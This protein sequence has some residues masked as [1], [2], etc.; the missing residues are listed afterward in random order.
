MKTLPLIQLIV[1]LLFV[2][3]IGA[4]SDDARVTLHEPHVYKG[5]VDAHQY[6]LLSQEKR[7]QQR[8]LLAFTDR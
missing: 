5:N 8:T 7:L 2:S 6:N 1:A 4:C 3:L